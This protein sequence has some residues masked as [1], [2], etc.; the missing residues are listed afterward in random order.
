MEHQQA[1]ASGPTTGEQAIQST[2]IKCTV[3]N[4]RYNQDKRCTAD[5]ILI[6]PHFAASS[7]DTVC[8]TFQRES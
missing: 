6:G 2:G 7:A 8:A 5:Q 1:F 3:N 4:C